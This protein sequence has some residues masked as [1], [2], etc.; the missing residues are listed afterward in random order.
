MWKFFKESAYA[1]YLGAAVTAFTGL[2]ISDWKWWAITVPTIILVVATK[3][4]RN[5]KY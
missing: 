3:K 1:M 5:D 4:D 2:T